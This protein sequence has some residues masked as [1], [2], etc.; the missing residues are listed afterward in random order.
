MNEKMIHRLASL[1]LVASLSVV[2]SCDYGGTEDEENKQSAALVS[3]AYVADQAYQASL[4]EQANH[5]AIN[6]TWID[7][8][9]GG[10]SY[11]L[12][13]TASVPVTNTIEANYGAGISVLSGA[14]GGTSEILS[15]D[16][17]A[18][19]YYYKHPT[20]GYGR[21]RWVG[22]ILG[23]NCPVSDIRTATGNASLNVVACVY[24]CAEVYS[25]ATLAAAQ[26]DT[27]TASVNALKTN[28]CGGFGWSMG[29]R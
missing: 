3:V 19:T 4:A 27:T 15:F 16:N 13:G 14:F 11:S 22:P 2:S 25:K 17:S 12:S 23:E 21:T 5:L 9:Y 29:Y 28:G 20:Y 18:N 6:G 7:G 1:A 8:Y 24:Y 10:G 26:A